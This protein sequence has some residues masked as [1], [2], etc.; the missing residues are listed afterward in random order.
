MPGGQCLAHLLVAFFLIAVIGLRGIEIGDDTL[1]YH[2][3]FNL[4]LHGVQESTQRFFYIE[5]MEFGYYLFQKFSLSLSGNFSFLLMLS[6]FLITL[7]VIFVVHRYSRI[8][9]FSYWIFL[10]YGFFLASMA[11]IRQ[12]IALGFCFLAY[13]F[14]VQRKLWLFLI[15][16]TAAF[17]FHMTSI[18]FLPFYWLS[19]IKYRS[20]YPV[21]FLLLLL[22][23]N[24]L[25]FFT[26]DEILQ[27]GAKFSRNVYV[28]TG[29]SSFL[30]IS[31]FFVCSMLLCVFFTGQY[32]NSDII[33]KTSWYSVA[34]YVAPLY[35]TAMSP[36]LERLFLYYKLPIILLLPNVAA[37]IESKA[38][39]RLFMLFFVAMGFYMYYRNLFGYDL[40]YYPYKF[41]WE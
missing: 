41:F 14:I 24:A 20:F 17:S 18:V 10:T 6:A 25:F 29:T 19:R 23:V 22:T 15:C 30:K 39:R 40:H 4:L 11:L 34:I 33:L 2:Y 21:I 31:V 12:S 5:G 26:M 28:V 13:H 32:F 8:P 35:A 16:I 1:V 27:W 3:R 36:A 7:P 37:R 9:L 38:L